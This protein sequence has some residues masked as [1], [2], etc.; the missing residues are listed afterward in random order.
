M[1]RKLGRKESVSKQE[2]KNAKLRP[3]LDDSTFDDLNVN[4]GMDYMDTEEPV[5]EGRLSKEIEE[6]NV[7]HDTEVLEKGGSKEEP[8]SNLMLF[9]PQLLWGTKDE[10]QS[11]PLFKWFSLLLILVPNSSPGSSQCL[12]LSILDGCNI[13]K[14]A[15]D[16]VTT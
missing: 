13:N 7:T 14:F 5:N 11:I 3:T 16:Q 15:H 12:A 10:I 4:H 1:N 8:S 6:L 2:R 9:D